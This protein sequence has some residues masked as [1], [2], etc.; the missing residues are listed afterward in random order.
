MLD[1]IEKKVIGDKFDYYYHVASEIV[2]YIVDNT[3]LF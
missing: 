2:N 1:I 3:K